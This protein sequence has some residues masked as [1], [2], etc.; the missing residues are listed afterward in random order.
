MKK[1]SQVQRKK[2]SVAKTAERREELRSALID[3]AERTIS[4]R[5]L[6]GLKARDLAEEV[7]CALGA[8][9]TVF[10]DLDS[11]ILAVNARTLAQ[12][13]RF[14]K[15][16][17]PAAARGSRHPAVDSLVDLALAYLTFAVENH[18]RWRALF[19]HRL[20]SPDEK[21][22]AWYA[23][24]QARL[25]RLVE[26]PLRELQPGLGEE[27]LA[28]FART[29]FSGVHGIVSLGL[30]A[31]LMALPAP[32]LEDQVRKFVRILAAGLIHAPLT[33]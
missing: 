7:G 2:R 18:P 17:A 23:E 9:Y 12:F 15:E 10:P 6:A 26:A 8:I 20:N 30:D 3:A 14:V 28:L 33:G 4:R 32:V 5:G 31:K 27:E 21:I 24:E 19:E 25:F 11:L 13:E 22:P 1:K 29:M 16:R